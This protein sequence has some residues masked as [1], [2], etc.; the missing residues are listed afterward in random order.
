MYDKD[1]AVA[2][3]PN[4]FTKNISSP[5]INQQ[6]SWD[7][8][9]LFTIPKEIQDGLVEYGFLKPSNIQAVAIPLIAQSVDGIYYNLIAQAKNG[10]GKTGAFAIGSVLRVDPKVQS[11]QVLVV[12]H[13][14][15]LSS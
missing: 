4:K 6:K 5:F 10:S 15:E 1:E 11:I 8:D 3:M 9:E 13:T 7:D 14:R 2:L 12:C